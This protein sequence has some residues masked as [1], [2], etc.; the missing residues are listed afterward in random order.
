MKMSVL[1]MCT[2]KTCVINKPYL[3]TQNLASKLGVR[4]IYETIS[5]VKSN[6][7]N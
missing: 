4:L 5:I 1:E 6:L 7:S 2:V 3:F